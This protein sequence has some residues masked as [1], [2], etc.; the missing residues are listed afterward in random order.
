MYCGKFW[1]TTFDISRLSFQKLFI[2]DLFQYYRQY[3][4][5]KKIVTA[6]CEIFLFSIGKIF[7]IIDVYMIVQ[8]KKNPWKVKGQVS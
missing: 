7:A 3:K 5:I 4:K 8:K 1:H 6:Y 2:C